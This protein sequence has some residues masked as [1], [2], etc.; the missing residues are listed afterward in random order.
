MPE[1]H[2]KIKNPELNM[3]ELE[4]FAAVMEKEIAELKEEV[5]V[6]AFTAAMEK[7]AELKEEVAGLV[8]EKEQFADK[9]KIMMKEAFSHIIDKANLH[10]K[11]RALEKELETE[12][13]KSKRAEAVFSQVAEANEAT[14]QDYLN[15]NLK[16]EAEFQSQ[17]KMLR[18]TEDFAERRQRQ[19]ADKQ[20]KVKDKC[21][22]TPV[23]M[24][25][26]HANWCDDCIK[27]PGRSQHAS[28][29]FK[30]I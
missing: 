14:I 4:A 10:E 13:N 24:E 17:L 5:E 29:P 21:C 7:V 16:M 18:D 23:C 11:V 1:F 25:R 2:V 6:E 20:E 30:R 8:V 3:P 15:K 12:K 9:I 22:I 28:Y 19:F 26:T 27:M